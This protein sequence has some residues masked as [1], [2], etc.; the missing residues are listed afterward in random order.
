[1]EHF[2]IDNNKISC[3]ILYAAHE[4]ALCGRIIIRD[5]PERD[6]SFEHRVEHRVKQSQAQSQADLHLD[7]RKQSQGPISSLEW[8]AHRIQ[9]S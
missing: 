4:G 8:A 2:D 6:K 9:I 5:G 7:D 3:L 1:M